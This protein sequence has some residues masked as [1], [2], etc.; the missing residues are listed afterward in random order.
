VAR[1]VR[2]VRILRNA[3]GVA[4]LAVV[5]PFSVKI[6]RRLAERSGLLLWH[7]RGCPAEPSLARTMASLSPETQGGIA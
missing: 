4:C 2:V 7:L 3:I 1:T 6:H 5:A